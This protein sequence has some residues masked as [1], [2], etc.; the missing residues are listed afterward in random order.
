MVNPSAEVAALM[1]KI[2][3][4]ILDAIVMAPLVCLLQIIGE[5]GPQT[6]MASK[7][8]VTTWLLR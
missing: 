1:G 4:S 5:I 8:M 6:E 2:Y 7:L 3:D